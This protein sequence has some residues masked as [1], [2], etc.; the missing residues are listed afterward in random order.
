[1]KKDAENEI[2]LFLKTFDPSK[3]T[4]FDTFA[5]QV[6][7]FSHVSPFPNRT[8]G[9]WRYTV[10]LAKAEIEDVN[11]IV[12]E[13]A[14]C[15]L[16]RV[17]EKLLQLIKPLYLLRKQEEKFW[18]NGQQQ[19]YLLEHFLA[20]LSELDDLPKEKLEE[21]VALQDIKTWQLTTTSH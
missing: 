1:M 12:H 17:I 9:E 11:T 13:I 3:F 15:T 14:E 5:F 6:H 7:G 19:K 18:V 16:G 20:T 21:R 4:D 8:N 2:E 10:Y